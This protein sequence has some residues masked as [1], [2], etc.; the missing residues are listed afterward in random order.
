MCSITVL[1]YSNMVNKGIIPNS[2][3]FKNAL[4]LNTAVKI[5]L[6]LHLAQILISAAAI[7]ITDLHQTAVL[8]YAVGI[9]GVTTPLI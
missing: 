7:P 8:T 4:S 3:L 5:V 1:S 2:D 9:C 6:S